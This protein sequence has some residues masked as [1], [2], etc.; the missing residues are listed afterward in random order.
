MGKKEKTKEIKKQRNTEAAFENAPIKKKLQISIG[1]VI[2]FAIVLAVLLLGAMKAIESYVEKM[3]HGPV[4]NA[5][6]VGDIR[7]A[8]A[9]IPQAVNYARAEGGV[10]DAD[11]KA[12]ALQA[13]EDVDAAWS[14][15]NAA[16][17]VLKD[18]LISEGSKDKLDNLIAQLFDHPVPL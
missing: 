4:T 1:M 14:L 3:Y 9:E 17:D 12:A 6:Y 16:Y 18:T 15:M 11:A 8:L 5:T 7:Y 2:A 10:G 13:Q